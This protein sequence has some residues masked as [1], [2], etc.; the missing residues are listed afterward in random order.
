MATSTICRTCHRDFQRQFD[1]EGYANVC[2]DCSTGDVDRVMG[3]VAWSGKHVMEL[4]I[5][6]N[7]HE[8]EMF[9]YVQRRN[10][11]GPLRSI[12]AGREPRYGQEAWED[13]SGAE[14]GAMYYSR[15]GEKHVVKR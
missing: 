14:K 4:E 12:I 2:L 10:C 1:H 15:L 5:T 3:K 7:R 11:A 9:N 6:S 8:A 13:G